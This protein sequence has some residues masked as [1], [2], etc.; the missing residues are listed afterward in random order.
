MVWG[1]LLFVSM[2]VVWSYASAPSHKDGE[3]LYRW[4]SPD[5][6]SGEP[7]SMWF[8]LVCLGPSRGQPITAECV[9]GRGTTA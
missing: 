6:G 3:A 7:V 4:P 8:G 5:I 9:K 1:E 2:N